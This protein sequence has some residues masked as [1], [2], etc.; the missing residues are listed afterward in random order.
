M[1]QKY[2]ILR[3]A[4][5]FFKKFGKNKILWWKLKNHFF[6]LPEYSI[7]PNGILK[8]NWL[9]I[10]QTCTEA[11]PKLGYIYQ[12]WSIFYFSFCH[13]NFSCVRA[14]SPISPNF[15]SSNISHIQRRVF[16]CFQSP[17]PTL[18]SPLQR[19]RVLLVGAPCTIL[20]MP[21][22]YLLSTWR[23]DKHFLTREKE[24]FDFASLGLCKH[25]N[26]CKHLNTW[27][28]L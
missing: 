5:F 16:I 4:E 22:I 28:P 17:W 14:T 6:N 3:N 19:L 26:P 11:G 7:P 9:I 10:R 12:Y 24:T 25:L 15:T 18:T 13:V 1:A 20:R 8:I 23:R 27:T 21:I 2:I